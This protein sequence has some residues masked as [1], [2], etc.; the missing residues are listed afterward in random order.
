MDTNAQL[1]LRLRQQALIAELGLAALR[2]EGL[3]PLL[4]Q[5]ARLAAEGLSSAFSKVLEYRAEEGSFLL[6]AGLGWRQGCVGHVLIGGDTE[7]PAGF[8]FRTG[9]PVIS[10][11]LAAEARFRTPAL[12]AEH[13]VRRA[14][15]VI[16]RGEAEPFGVLEVDSRDEG[17]FTADDINFLQALANTLGVAVDR[18][19][20]QAAL[21]ELTALAEA[22]AREA[23]A[24]LA[25][26][27]ALLRE[28]DLLM[29]EIEH[30]VKNSLTITRSLLS[31]QAR[32]T[33]PEAGRAALEDAARRVASIARVHDRLHR[34]RR[35]GVVD[36]GE[37]LSGLCEELER[38]CGLAESGRG[39]ALLLEGIECPAD[40]AVTLGLIVTELVT[41]AAKHGGGT[42]TVECVTLGEA[43][44]PQS[45]RLRVGDGGPG[46]PPGLDPAQGGRLGLQLIR[47]L[48][49]RLGGLPRWEAAPEGG[50]RFELV[51][52][53]PVNPDAAERAAG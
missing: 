12:M 2:R 26:R 48:G 8:A 32:M 38:S 31:L 49:E 52:P 1:T 28:K 33:A 39:L 17:D 47:S 50:Q 40:E 23:E 27:D 10:N 29:Q 43:P 45:L 51:F 4:D 15:N 34:S 24:A 9:R 7:S 22:R 6:R 16:I 21:R 18:E 20:S 30:R 46:L 14:I 53:W 37:Y 41:N 11:H 5:A 36:L 42:V 35:I 13:G 25:A 44:G 19:L 3:Q